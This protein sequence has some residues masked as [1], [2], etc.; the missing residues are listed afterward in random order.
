[1]EDGALPAD[2]ANPAYPPLHKWLPSRDIFPSAGA[3]SY[4]DIVGMVPGEANDNPSHLQEIKL[5]FLSK[6]VNDTCY[7]SPGAEA[8]MV[9]NGFSDS[10]LYVTICR[11]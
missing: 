5:R 10:S 8:R 1:M 9:G 3:S 4:L 11:F 6:Q 7:S 2:L